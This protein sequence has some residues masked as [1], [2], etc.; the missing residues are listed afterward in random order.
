MEP[1]HEAGCHACVSIPG[2][3]KFI[4]DLF[5]FADREPSVDDEQDR[6]HREGGECG[7]LEQEADHDQDEAE[8]LGVAD[9]CVGA[10]RPGGPPSVP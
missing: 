2:F 5:F 9:A 7:P 4:L 1:G 8:V 6:E 10:G 3:P